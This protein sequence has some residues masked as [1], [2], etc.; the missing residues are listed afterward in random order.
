[1]AVAA[2]IYI[3]L[4]MTTAL[5]ARG[6]ALRKTVR[7][8]AIANCRRLNRAPGG[9][10]GP[11]TGW[12]TGKCRTLC[13]QPPIKPCMRAFQASMRSFQACMRDSRALNALATTA[14]CSALNVS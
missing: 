4:F 10:A 3:D 6:S 8:L 9:T 7:R 13:V 2:L 5:S 14:F 11:E 12:R 1:M